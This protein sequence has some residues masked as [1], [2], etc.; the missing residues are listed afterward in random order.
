M[1]QNLVMRQLDERQTEQ[2]IWLL[3]YSPKM[4]I[5]ALGLAT[6]AFSLYR[7]QWQRI[8]SAAPAEDA[9]LATAPGRQAAGRPGQ[10]RPP[11]RPTHRGEHGHPQPAAGQ[12]GDLPGLTGL[13][14]PR[15]RPRGP[16]VGLP[17]QAA[18]PQQDLQLHGS[19]RPGAALG[20]P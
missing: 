15:T 17:R 7:L 11:H 10:L 14:G 2:E 13:P 16:G 9:R 19:G 6:G 5:L 8:W 1:A 4:D 3:V 12:R 18:Q 20:L